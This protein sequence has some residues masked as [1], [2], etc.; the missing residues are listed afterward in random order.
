M[1]PER[2][3]GASVRADDDVRPAAGPP[4]ARTPVPDGGHGLPG[5]GYG[6]AGAVRGRAAARTGT[7]RY[8][9]EYPGT[10]AS[11]G[12]R[13]GVRGARTAGHGSRGAPVVAC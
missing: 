3:D 8:L 11:A 12:A 5:R 9:R 2:W 1:G 6:R 7:G 13:R 10:R 4:D